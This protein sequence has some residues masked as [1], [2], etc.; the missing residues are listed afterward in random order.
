MAKLNEILHSEEGLVNGLLLNILRQQLLL[1]LLNHLDL[2]SLLLPLLLLLLLLFLLLL[3]PLKLHL[4]LLLLLP[5]LP[6]LLIPPPLPEQLPRE[7]PLP[8][9]HILIDRG[10]AARLRT[11]L[12]QLKLTEGQYFRDED[13]FELVGQEYVAT[14][15]EFVQGVVLADLAHLLALFQQVD[16]LGE[17][18]EFD[19]VGGQHGGFREVFWEEVA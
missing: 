7:H 5:V 14:D 11:V 15:L 2:F 8:T 19:E 16:D 13:F 9:L 17:L 12:P 3:L 6:L 1:M 18:G 10:F 4:H